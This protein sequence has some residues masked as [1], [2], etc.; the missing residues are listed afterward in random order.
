MTPKRFPQITME[1]VPEQSRAL[2]Q[3]ILSFS[4]VGLAGPYNV[5]LRSP[6][7]AERM[8]RLLD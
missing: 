8:K 5:M 2:A 4:A 1:T 7:F 6:V 3:E